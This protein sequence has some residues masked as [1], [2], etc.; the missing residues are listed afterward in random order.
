MLIENLGRAIGQ[1]ALAHH[2][3]HTAGRQ[4]SAQPPS[5]RGHERDNETMRWE[6]P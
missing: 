1:V 5:V 4:Q 3:F 6:R 2:R